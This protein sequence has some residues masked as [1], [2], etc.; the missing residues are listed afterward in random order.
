MPATTRPPFAPLANPVRDYAWGS[1]TAIP[2]LTGTAP[3]GGP[4]AELW[5]G[6]HPSAPS[7]L[8]DGDG[9]PRSLDELVAEDPEGHLG[10]DT[11]KRF[12]P[13]LPFLLKVL[14]AERALSI[15]VHPTRAQAEAGHAAEEARG[16]RPDAPHR[17]F[18]DR[19]HKPELICALGDFE[20][21]CGFRPA[22]ATARLLDELAV[23]LLA[24]WSAALRRRPA[25]EVLPALLRHVLAD[26]RPGPAELAS[27]AGALARV[28][29][30]GGPFAAA[31]A[32]YARAAR[33][34]PGDP[35][36][37]AALLLNHVRLRAGQALFLDAGVPHAYLHGLGV[38]LMA[39]S[40]NVLRCGLTAKHLDVDGLLAVTS[41][42]TGEPGVLT[43]AP[44]AGGVEEVF[45]SPAA[46]F[47]L[48][49][50]RPTGT[51]MRIDLPGAPQILLCTAGRAVLG[52]PDGRRLT[53]NAGGS[54]YLRPDGGPVHL[55]GTG[56][57]LFR[58]TT[59][60]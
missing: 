1:T 58:A 4:Q 46:E 11:V 3:T 49:R 31:C 18:R 54:A 45:P 36:L 57:Q 35:G 16:V 39:N 50:L 51:P 29:D 25:G 41:F 40:D 17:T 56:A 5:L 21:L 13:E 15:Q 26:V 14:A 34:Y 47:R 22:A 23:P 32:A 9:P 6:A 7:L 24:P 55:T 27:L 8:D 28:A 20:A 44:V 60:G 33:D 19:G 30:G 2:A 38:E 37:V 43:A 48:S 52:A 53:L 12:G 42:R 59:G 10:T